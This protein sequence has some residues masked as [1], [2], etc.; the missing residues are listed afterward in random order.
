M[1][2]ASLADSTSQSQAASLQHL[3]AYANDLQLA[4]QQY[5]ATVNRLKVRHVAA[6]APV[7]MRQLI[8]AEDNLLRLCLGVWWTACLR[9][10]REETIA[11]QQASHDALMGAVASFLRAR[12]AAIA[13]SAVADALRSWRIVAR[14][15]CQVRRAVGHKLAS[16]HRHRSWL[17]GIVAETFCAWRTAVSQSHQDQQSQALRAQR[18]DLRSA[19]GESRCQHADMERKVQ[20][21]EARRRELLADVQKVLHATRVAL[22][23]GSSASL[24]GEF[25]SGGKGAPPA[26]HCHVDEEQLLAEIEALHQL[27]VD[28][29]ADLARAYDALSSSTCGQNQN[30]AGSAETSFSEV[31]SPA[32]AAPAAE[33]LSATVRRLRVE[34]ARMLEEL[35]AVRATAAAAADAESSRAAKELVREQAKTHELSFRLSQARDLV[36]DLK[37]RQR[38]LAAAD[39]GVGRAADGGAPSTSQGVPRVHDAV[40]ALARVSEQ[41]ADPLPEGEGEAA[42]CSFSEST[43]DAGTPRSFLWGGLPKVQE[44]LGTLAR[45]SLELAAPPEPEAA[46]LAR[47]EAQAQAA[48]PGD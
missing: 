15:L 26:H 12:W 36:S 33:Q 20:Q 3:V 34:R 10:R 21:A 47:R 22:T 30:R 45:L 9:C 11:G 28:V 48:L 40:G 37:A 24:A 29:R 27:R 39:A 6:L 14:L 19:L 1:F 32:P 18:R 44:A 13:L 31:T 16:H 42:S 41:L 4:E 46:Q 5:Q 8:L 43:I 23:I 17:E 25:G 2:S 35:S 7:L 38:R